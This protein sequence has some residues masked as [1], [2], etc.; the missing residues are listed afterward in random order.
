MRFLPISEGH[1]D[2][3][4]GGRRAAAVGADD[5]EALGAAN[6]ALVL[7]ERVQRRVGES[8]GGGAT[9]AQVHGLRHVT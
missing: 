7:L 4:A 5:V 1:L 2:H 9:V 6:H 3:R 8:D